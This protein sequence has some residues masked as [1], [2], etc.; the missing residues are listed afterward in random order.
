MAR[1]GKTGCAAASCVESSIERI[2]DPGSW[3]SDFR[4]LRGP[5]RLY[6]ETSL[7]RRALRATSVLLAEDAGRRLPC[8]LV[9]LDKGRSEGQ[10]Q[11]RPSWRGTYVAGNEP[12]AGRRRI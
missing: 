9:G 3:R 1:S 11:R 8:D 6:G 12:V 2:A 4:S 5:V 7:S 10:N